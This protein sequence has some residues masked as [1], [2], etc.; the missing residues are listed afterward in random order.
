MVGE[1]G[2]EAVLPPVRVR[3]WLAATTTFLL[4]F[5]CV[6]LVVPM[7]RAVAAAASM[8]GLSMLVPAIP[9]PVMLKLPV[10]GVP[11]LEAC[12]VTPP[13]APQPVDITQM[14][15]EASGSVQ[16]REPVRSVLVMVPIN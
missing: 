15:P 11:G 9:L 1:P 3:D 2:R 7:L 13:P 16:V 5:I 6:A 4:R 12:R 10:S 8:S 14:T